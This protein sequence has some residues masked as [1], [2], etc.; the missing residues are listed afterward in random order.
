MGLEIHER[1]YAYSEPNIHDTMQAINYTTFYHYTIYN[2]SSINYH[3]VFISN[4]SDI[5]LGNYTDDYLGTD[6]VNGFL[7]G[8]NALP[9]DS[10]IA[11]VSAVC[12]GYGNKPPVSSIVLIKTD[13]SGDGIDNDL[14]SQIDEPGE[15]FMM[16][17]VTYH[18]LLSSY[19]LAPPPTSN[20]NSPA[21]YYGYM[22]GLWKDNTPYTFGGN[23][24]GGSV[25]TNW[26]Y[27]GNPQNNTGW[28]ELTAG[29]VPHD[30]RGVLS[31]GPFNFPAKSRIEWGFAIVFSQDTTQA[32]NTIT[33]F[34]S[35][36]QRDVRNIKYYHSTHDKPQ[37]TPSLS[38]VGIRPNSPAKLEAL[39]YPNPSAG[40]VNI[41]LKENVEKAFIYVTDVLGR[42]ILAGEIHSGYRGALDLSPLEKGIYFIDITSGGR[43][44]TEKIIKN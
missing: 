29:N 35:R 6:T 28:T 15:Q 20:P 10:N 25:P 5:D 3:D 8:Y 41:D 34:D 37:C 7:Y 12:L 44:Y 17:R 27:T 36:V 21:D 42:N 31:S 13:C 4:W 24:Y 23:A 18:N 1:S 2:R 14:D 33:E 16:N 32:V 30:H 9:Y 39:I 11:G 38:T 22:S 40:N 19:S 26:I 43:K